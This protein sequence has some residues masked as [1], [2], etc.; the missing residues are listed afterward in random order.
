QN[1]NYITQHVAM[2]TIY[3]QPCTVFRKTQQTTRKILAFEK[4]RHEQ[5]YILL[6]TYC[7]HA[8]IR[9]FTVIYGK[10]LQRV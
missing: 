2:S 3:K 10:T 5:A 4:E 9:H 1:I 8:T 7:R 6:K